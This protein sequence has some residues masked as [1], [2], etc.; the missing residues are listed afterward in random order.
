VIA[1]YLNYCNMFESPLEA[2]EFF[3]A[4]RSIIEKGVTQPSQRRYTVENILLSLVLLSPILITANVV[5]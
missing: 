2:L 5:S 1:C 4:K 3:G